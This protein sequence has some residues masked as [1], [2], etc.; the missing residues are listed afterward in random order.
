[1]KTIDTGHGYIHYY[2]KIAAKT[3]PTVL[4][5]QGSSGA[6]CYLGFKNIITAL[7]DKYGI[8]AIDQLGYGESDLTRSERT[9]DNILAETQSIVNK[10]QIH[11]VI[12]FAHSLGGLYAL[13][14]IKRFSDYVQAVIGVEPVTGVTEM[15]V[16]DMVR[17]TKEEAQEV[18]RD[19]AQGKIPESELKSLINPNLNSVDWNKQLEIFQKLLDNETQVN[20]AENLKSSIQSVKK[21]SIPNK[22]PVL[23]FS[24]TKR[25]SEYQ[26]SEFKNDHPF[27]KISCFGDSHFLH[28]T[29]SSRVIHETTNFLNQLL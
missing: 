4:F 5:F 25:Q 14:Y 29:E 28:W 16:D 21:I 20:E 18:A 12:I 26:T 15:D 3:Y 10:E 11:K 8:L 6:N 19:R 23:I 24:R 2:F 9:I 27:S 7:P 1:M 17:V 13:G 22:I